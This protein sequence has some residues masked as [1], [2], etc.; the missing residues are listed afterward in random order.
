MLALRRLATC[1]VVDLEV[2]YSARSPDEYRTKLTELRDGYVHLPIT[3][4]VCAR[5][6]EVQSTLATRSHHRGCG[7]SD[8]LI[9]ACAEIHGVQV[10]HYDRD[11]D[12]IASVTGQSVKWVVPRGSVPEGRPTRPGE[13]TGNGRRGG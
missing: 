2:L 9:A 6:L 12:L 1:A 7:V 5:A 3:P 11:F 4:A 10:L 13:W 8:L